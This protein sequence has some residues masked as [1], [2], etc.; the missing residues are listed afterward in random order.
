MKTIV[1][2]MNRFTQRVGL[3][4]TQEDFFEIQDQI[5]RMESC[6]LVAWEKGNDVCVYI[7]KW[8]GLE[9]FG[10]YNLSAKK[11]VSFKA[12]KEQIYIDAEKHFDS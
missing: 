10:V 12:L 11:I 4:L 5:V 6:T 8:R 1:H 3:D 2:A 9:F 7:V